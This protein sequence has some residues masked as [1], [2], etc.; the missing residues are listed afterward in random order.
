MAGTPVGLDFGA[1]MTVGAALG[2]DLSLLAE[3]LPDVEL[4]IIAGLSGDTDP[5][6]EPDD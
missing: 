2:A 1:I 3:I 6:E 4:T 5:D